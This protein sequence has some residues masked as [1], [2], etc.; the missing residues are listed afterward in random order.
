L[1]PADAKQNELVSDDV[2]KINNESNGP[3]VKLFISNNKYVS[4]ILDAGDSNNWEHGGNNMLL[5]KGALEEHFASKDLIPVQASSSNQL[6]DKDFVN[7]SIAT[8]TATYGGSYNLV[9]DLEL[10]LNATQEQ[11]ATALA[12]AID[13]SDNNDYCFV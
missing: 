13:I 8:A 4:K 3:H 11:I 12:S 6:A 1:F 10:S 2:V 7:S 9:S 5:T